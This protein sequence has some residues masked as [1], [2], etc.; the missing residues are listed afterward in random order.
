MKFCSLKISLQ[1]FNKI[2]MFN[3]QKTE[4]DSKLIDL[5]RVARVTAGGKRFNF[6]ATVVVGNHNGR[7]GLGVA[8]GAD[9]AAAIEKATRAAKKKAIQISLTENGSILEET[10][11]KFG[12]AYVKIKPVFKGGR[13]LIAG[14]AVRI[15]L[16]LAG[17]KNASAKI[18]SVSK[19]KINNAKAAIEALKK[20]K[21]QNSNLKT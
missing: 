20:I 10:E 5:R 6:R 15:V 14:G 17:V 7:V 13:G 18:I 19:N 2:S 1:N 3:Q 8:K 11:A 21:T 12:S 9:T 4:Y 16:A